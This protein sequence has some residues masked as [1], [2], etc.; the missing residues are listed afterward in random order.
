MFIGE[1]S[2]NKSILNHE[3]LLEML[4]D[5]LREPKEFWENFHKDRTKEIPF[6]KINGPDENLVEYFVKGLVLI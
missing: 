4:D 1:K 6:F 3:D 5:F 2:M